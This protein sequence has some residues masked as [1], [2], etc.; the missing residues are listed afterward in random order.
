MGANYR[1]KGPLGDPIGGHFPFKSPTRELKIEPCVMKTGGSG[2]LTLP[3]FKQEIQHK[4]KSTENKH[5]K[6]GGQFRRRRRRRKKEKQN[7]RGQ[8]K[9]EHKQKAENN[10]NRK[11]TKKPVSPKP[12]EA[13]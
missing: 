9:T 13:Y 5:T 1:P 2:W 10:N 3:H 12:R 4:K 11:A 6:R 8:K 7:N